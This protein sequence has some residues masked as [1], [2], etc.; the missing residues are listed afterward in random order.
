MHL[1]SRVMFSCCLNNKDEYWI[2]RL[3]GQTDNVEDL[4]RRKSY[5]EQELDTFQSKGLNER[6]SVLVVPL[7]LLCSLWFSVLHHFWV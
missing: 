1:L 4:R 7:F 3:T 5:W 6:V 2:I